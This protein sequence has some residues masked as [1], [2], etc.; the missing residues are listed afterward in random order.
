[1]KAVELME[2]HPDI[3]SGTAQVWKT[4]PS[5]LKN[6]AE[7]AAKLLAS[8]PG[9]LKIGK[10]GALPAA[11]LRGSTSEVSKSFAAPIADRL[12]QK[13]KIP[14]PGAPLLPNHPKVQPSPGFELEPDVRSTPLSVT[15]SSGTP[16]SVTPSSGAD[17]FRT[18]TT[19]P[20][21]PTQP[22][23][24]FAVQAN[25]STATSPADQRAAEKAVIARRNKKSAADRWEDV[26]SW[27]DTE[28]D[29]PEVVSVG[30]SDSGAEL[31][32][33][34]DS[35]IPY[36]LGMAS[37]DLYSRWT[38]TRRALADD[39]TTTE[40]DPEI[41]YTVRGTDQTFGVDDRRLFIRLKDG[42]V[43]DSEE[44]KPDNLTELAYT[45][46]SGR[47]ITT[48]DLEAASE[49]AD[50]NVVL[51]PDGQPISRDEI[52]TLDIY[53]WKT[54]SGKVVYEEDLPTTAE[55]MESMLD[56]IRA[57]DGETI[58]VNGDGSVPEELVGNIES[59]QA[60]QRGFLN[61]GVLN[62]RA[63]WEDKAGNTA[64]FDEEYEWSPGNLSEVAPWMTDAILSTLPYLHPATAAVATV[65][66]MTPYLYGLDGS[67]YK[68]DY[69]KFADHTTGTF[70]RNE[71]LTRGQALGG[72]SAPIVY[73]LAERLFSGGKAIG[74]ADEGKLA[75]LISKHLGTGK[76]AKLAQGTVSAGR[77]GFEEILA[78]PFQRLQEEGWSTYARP[79]SYNELTGEVVVDKDAPVDWRDVA[80]GLATAGAEG[81]VIT[82]PLGAMQSGISKLSARRASQRAIRQQLLELERDRKDEGEHVDG[83]QSED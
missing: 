75:Q 28:V 47:I 2:L 30:E 17:F 60:D 49:T 16:F 8:Q 45:D 13:P 18:P 80:K 15:S 51:L 56:S 48:E 69:T 41:E 81:V 39:Q 37:K 64:F 7:G 73:L 78:E 11:Q 5:S 65:G 20:T 23:G 71:D 34:A 66:E 74:I 35:S 3:F 58:L 32:R 22:A 70:E 21:A 6:V 76:R 67:S 77:E 33:K 83:D 29:E 9:A 14:E 68:P 26:A 63:P 24:M 61:M 54:P 31:V 44:I 62:P 42:Q 4:P 10:D 59:S 55:E 19:K 43:V 38:N 50:P 72:I 27:M 46:K 36:A 52:A 25:A 40:D 82:P 1:M 57:P 12:A 53:V 79:R